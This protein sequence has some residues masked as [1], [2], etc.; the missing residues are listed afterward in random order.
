MQIKSLI[1]DIHDFPKPGI[2]YRDITTLLK[3]PQGLSYVIDQLSNLFTNE[4]ID[5]VVG[6]ESRGF[7]FGAPVAYKLE[8]GFVP[9]RKAGKL[10]DE[11]HSI[12][13]ELEYGND[14]LEIHQD[15]ITPGDRVLIIDD[16]MA[17]GGTAEA[18]AKLVENLGCEL[19]GFAFIVELL[20]LAGR[21]KLPG[22]PIHSLVTY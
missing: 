4:N 22:V 14:R 7:I 10:P 17:T 19:V 5:Y 3:N 15:A 16:L 20:A 13:Y 2:V 21:E 1:R 9:V 11:T 8:A 12:E 18:T 6:I